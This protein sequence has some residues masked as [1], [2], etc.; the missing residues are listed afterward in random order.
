MKIKLFL[1]LKPGGAR[2]R[3]KCKN[4]RHRFDILNI[5][6]STVFIYIEMMIDAG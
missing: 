5:N 2:Q 6:K 3:K 1:C 4:E